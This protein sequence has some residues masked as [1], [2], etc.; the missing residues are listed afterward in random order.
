MTRYLKR[1][2]NPSLLFHTKRTRDFGVGE[3]RARTLF[4][5]KHI[6]KISTT[7]TM[8][9]PSGAFSIDLV[10]YKINATDTEPFYYRAV[11]PLDIV[12]ISLGEET[13]MIG[14]VDRVSKSTRIAK[15]GVN[16]VITITGRSLG[17][18][19]EFDL[20][21]YFTNTIGLSQDLLDRNLLLQ[22]GAIAKDFLEKP[23]Y[24]AIMEIYRQLPMFEMTLYGNQKVSD[25]LDV[26]SELFARV[27]E[28]VFNT[29][30]AAYSGTVW[31]YFKRYLQPPFNEL[32]T[33][34]RDGKLYMRSRPSPFSLSD[35]EKAETPKVV[36]NDG[37]TI[38]D[39]KSEEFGW[40]KIKNWIGGDPY[41]T[42]NLEDIQTESM[43]VE[44]GRAYSHFAV[45]PSDRFTSRDSEYAAFKPLIDSDLAKE[46]GVR[47]MQVRLN[48]IPLI[49]SGKKTDGTLERHDYYRNKAY[50]WNRDN[51][52]MENGRM[53]I[54]G[55]PDIRVGDR[56]YR[57]DLDKEYYVTEVSNNYIYGKPFL[58]TLTVE[59]GLTRD[60]RKK[61]YDAGLAFV[62]GL[63][64]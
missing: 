1:R 41:H 62:K 11:Q 61:L 40:N 13:T 8:G 34:S 10:Y 58:S 23:P 32:W 49:K 20:I 24:T 44:H 4:P 22:N 30:L 3:A 15:G 5:M 45:L 60:N 12:E 57:P 25:F 59:R 26:G 54:I 38:S 48:Y 19:W 53:T 51:H 47:D 16:R 33:E 29:H 28:L 17:S 9:K 50:L 6:L 42:I 18:I 21:K 27:N 14:M 37:R 36:D 55:N 35:T 46:I 64:A 56:V 7:N 39:K 52:R 63:A 43:S 2:P 31:D